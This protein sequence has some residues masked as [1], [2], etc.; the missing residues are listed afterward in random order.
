MIPVCKNNP[1]LQKFYNTIPGRMVSLIIVKL[2]TWY[3]AGYCLIPFVY[4]G[5]TK[6][7]QVYK[8]LFFFGH[9]IIFPLSVLWLPIFVHIINVLFPIEKKQE[10]QNGQSKQEQSKKVN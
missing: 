2:Y 5:F 10:D 1:K 3:V 8:T 7:W 9:I 4:L 6:W